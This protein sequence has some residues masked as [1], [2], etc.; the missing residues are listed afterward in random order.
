MITITF[1]VCTFPISLCINVSCMYFIFCT[2][3]ALSIWLSSGFGALQ[4]SCIIIIIIVSR[5]ICRSLQARTV[6]VLA[7]RVCYFLSWLGVPHGNSPGSGLIFRP[8]ISHDKSVFKVHLLPTVIGINS[9]LNH[10]MLEHCRLR[11]KVINIR[12][13]NGTPIAVERRS[14]VIHHN[15]QNIGS[16]CKEKL[17]KW[18]IILKMPIYR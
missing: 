10:C 15:E 2:S 17:I 9:H 4:I 14:K 12:R 13:K 6:S 5:I 16:A 11:R 7:L 3:C 18:K 8:L 1:H